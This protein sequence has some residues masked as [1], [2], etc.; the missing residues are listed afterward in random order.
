[1]S[2]GDIVPR[3]SSFAEI[4]ATVR[5]K[6]LKPWFDVEIDGVKIG[7]VETSRHTELFVEKKIVIPWISGPN[8]RLAD[9]FVGFWGV[10][11]RPEG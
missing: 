6:W 1:M 2:Q 3:D 11:C 5:S 9:D 4:D 7:E 10:S 8:L